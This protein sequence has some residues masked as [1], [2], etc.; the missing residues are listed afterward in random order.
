MKCHHCGEPIEVGEAEQPVIIGNK[1]RHFL[2][3]HYTL[4]KENVARHYQEQL[5][6]Q[7][8]THEGR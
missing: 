6:L 3:G 5:R 4:Y 7:Q 8:S 2:P 1:P